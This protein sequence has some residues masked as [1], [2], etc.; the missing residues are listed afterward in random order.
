[1][2]GIIPAGSWASAGKASNKQ[3][4]SRVPTLSS[5]LEFLNSFL[6]QDALSQQ[7]KANLDTEEGF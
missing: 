1:M 5:C 2:G 3:H 7:Q 4:S 6:P